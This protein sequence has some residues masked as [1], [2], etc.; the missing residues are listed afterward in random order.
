MGKTKGA[1]IIITLECSLCRSAKES[2]DSSFLDKTGVSRYVTSKNRRTTAKKLEL[3]K[4]CKY[5]KQPT[6]HKEIK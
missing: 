2:S 1:R 6:K 5:C 4:Y 3:N